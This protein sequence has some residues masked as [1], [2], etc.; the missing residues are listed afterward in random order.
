MSVHPRVRSRSPAGGRVGRPDRRTREVGAVR[1][2]FHEELQGLSDTLVE[3]T[4]LVHSAMTRAT[5]ALLDGDL[6]LAESV[7]GA[8][9]RLDKLHHELEERAYTLLA[10]QAPVAS[11]LRTIVSA[12]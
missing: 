12:L 1:E 10:R 4:G 6:S 5:T 8:D 9:E 11:D 7:I 3:M 2:A